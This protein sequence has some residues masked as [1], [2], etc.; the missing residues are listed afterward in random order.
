VRRCGAV[1]W[2][3]MSSEKGIFLYRER[4]VYDSEHDMH[5]DVESAYTGVN[6]SSGIRRA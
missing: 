5:S 4:N 6:A 1:Q 3:V 2:L